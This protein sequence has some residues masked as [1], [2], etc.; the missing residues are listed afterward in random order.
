MREAVDEAR[1]WLGT[2]Y[3]HGAS[4]KGAG[5]DCLGLIRG[6]W[7][8]IYGGEPE[9]V[10]IYTP[11][12]SEPQGD[13]A[14]L[15]AATRL[16]RPVPAGRAFASGEM[17]IFRMR[18]FGVAKHMGILANASDAPSFVHAYE[19]RGVIESSLSSPW[20]RRV[21]ARFDFPTED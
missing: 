14:L 11:D 10:P 15:R 16:M 7:R 5:T 12:W 13:E 9:A 17:L 6:V 8:A 19:R 3:L 18:S 2:P 21:A 4:V 1:R 20:A